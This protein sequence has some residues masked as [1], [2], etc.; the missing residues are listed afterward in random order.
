MAFSASWCP[1]CQRM[2]PALAQAGPGF[3]VIDVDAEPAITRAFDVT[4][5]P[6]LI[7]LVEDRETARAF[8]ARDVSGLRRFRDEGR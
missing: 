4:R 8:G 1:A 5:L 6:T 3:E 2:K 7:R